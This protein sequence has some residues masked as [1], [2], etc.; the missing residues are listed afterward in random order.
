MEL[1]K[2][3]IDLA[4]LIA[5]NPCTTRAA[6]EFSIVGRG[7]IP[8][9]PGDVLSSNA[10]EFAW[11]EPLKQQTVGQTVGAIASNSTHENKIVSRTR[12]VIP[13]QGWVINPAKGEVTLIAH[14]P[15]EQFAQR[16]WHP[17]SVCI[18]Q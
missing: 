2:N 16:T 8:P 10:T 6:S 14:Q 5:A 17:L 1:P 3:I 4:Q 12:E 15:N 13:A 11:V 7:G 9:S 18:P